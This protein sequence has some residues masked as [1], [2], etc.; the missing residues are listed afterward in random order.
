MSSYA[1]D[2][3]VLVYTLSKNPLFKGQGMNILGF[4][5]NLN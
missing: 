1:S 5:N 3:W 4:K 2:V